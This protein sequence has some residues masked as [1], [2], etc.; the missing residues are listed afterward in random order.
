MFLVFKLSKA[1]AS[2]FYYQNNNKLERIIT[3]HVDSFLSAGHEHFFKDVIPKIREKFAK[4][5]EC[6][7]AF[8]YFRLDLKEHK[9]C[10]FLH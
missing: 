2:L 6:D 3:I 4:G 5:K 10:I 9:N 8:R 1:D 7:T